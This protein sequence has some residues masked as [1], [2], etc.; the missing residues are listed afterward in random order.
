MYSFL[1]DMA[2]RAFAIDARK[3]SGFRP[4]P[5][6]LQEIMPTPATWDVVGP[7]VAPLVWNRED[8][9][10]AG[11]GPAG[12]LVEHGLRISSLPHVNPDKD[13]HARWLRLSDARMRTVR[14]GHWKLGL[15]ATLKRRRDKA[16]SVTRLDGD[17]VVLG[18]YYSDCRNYFHFWADAMCD[19]WFLGQCGVDLASVRHFLMPWNGA[20]W[21][22]EI[23]RLCGIPRERIVPLSSA[24]GFEVE[25]AHV[26]VRI[27]G[28][29]R[30][31]DWIVRALHEI[32]GW[33]QPVRT[34]PG[35]RLYITRGGALR[36]PFLNEAEVL[37]ALAPYGFE[38]VDC[39]T[40]SVADQRTLFA[41][42]EMVV[43]PHGAGL[44]NIVWAAPGTVL[45]EFMPRRHAN[46]CFMDLAAQA[47]LVY[48]NIPSVSE[49]DDVEPL[50][51]GFSVDAGE[52]AAMLRD[53]ARTG[54]S[55]AGLASD[56][57]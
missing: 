45:L 24:D 8:L 30:S 22:E 38:V 17:A 4:A 1:I 18:A 50:F 12:V 29:N 21:Q 42:A 43:A 46:P 23:V 49:E 52:V 31:H 9:A 7:D 47:G 55:A 35:R 28:G 32:S 25:R 5:D 27:K 39:A 57:G 6:R 10:L 44:T 54:A 2:D 33:R 16:M 11:G 34:L 15:G 13:E 19:A 40:L 20:G 36:R 53:V 51:A 56:G 3:R 37:E 48:R 14:F 41:Q 26:P